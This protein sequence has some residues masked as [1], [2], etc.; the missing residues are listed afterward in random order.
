MTTTTTPEPLRTE[1]Q[2]KALHALLNRLGM[3]TEAKRDM[4]SAAT[5]GRTQSSKELTEAEAKALID[6][7]QTRAKALPFAPKPGDTQRKKIISMARTLGW[8]VIARNGQQAADMRRIDNWCVKYGKFGKRLG[9]HT[10]K[11]LNQLVTQFGEMA[12]RTLQND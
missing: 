10:V 7:L 5:A 6:G 1:A 12:R 11:E 8:E 2:N 3:D 4:I 9:D